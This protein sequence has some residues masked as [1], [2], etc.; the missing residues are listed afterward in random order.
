MEAA[1]SGIPLLATDVG[2]N[3]EIVGDSPWSLLSSNPSANEIAATLHQIFS[4]PPDEA[5]SL[6]LAARRT[7]A[8]RFSAEIN[9]F[10]FAQ[11]LR[12]AIQ[13]FSLSHGHQRG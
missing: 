13:E 10:Q 1:S 9:Y 4:L 8:S 7:W 5:Q 6:R 3:P 2:G 11:D 12:F